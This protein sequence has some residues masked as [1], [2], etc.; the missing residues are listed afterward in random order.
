[1]PST[2]AG[3]SGGGSQSSAPAKKSTSRASSSRPANSRQAAVGSAW[4]KDNNV[5]GVEKY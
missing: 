2:D 3:K 5:Q 4:G 1:M